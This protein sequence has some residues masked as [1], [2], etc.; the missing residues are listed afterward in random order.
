MK[1]HPIYTKYSA[2][3]L[4]KI[5][6][7]RGE[8]TPHFHKSTGYLRFSI[9]HD[10]KIKSIAA[11]R[12]IWECIN[13]LIADDTLEIN[14]KDG[15]KTHN[16]LVN[17]ELVTASENCLHRSTLYPETGRGESNAAAK[18]SEIQAKEL[19]SLLPY[20]RNVELGLQFG[21]HPQYVSLIR[22]GKRWKHLQ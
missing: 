13:G 5:I 17:L 16:K 18:L 19:I 12:F 7:I 6:G 20:K 11:H 15:D 14:H 22:T 10:G 9:R 4:G 21:L 8:I 3:E 2:N 1:P